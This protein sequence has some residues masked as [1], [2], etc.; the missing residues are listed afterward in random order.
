MGW[1]FP[2]AH[3][4]NPLLRRGVGGGERVGTLFWTLFPCQS[5]VNGALL[6]CPPWLLNK[7]PSLRLV[8]MLAPI[9]NDWALSWICLERCP[10]ILMAVLSYLTLLLCPP[11]LFFSHLNSFLS[12]SVYP[13]VTISTIPF[14]VSIYLSFFDC[15]EFSHTETRTG[16]NAD[17]GSFSYHIVI[18]EYPA[19][20]V[21]ACMNRGAAAFSHVPCLRHIKARCCI[22]WAAISL[23]WSLCQYGSGPG[24][25]PF[26]FSPARLSPLVNEALCL[27]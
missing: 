14:F 23:L 12:N 20:Q 24:L 16:I 4:A 21:T 15:F 17:R 19:L 13:W 18:D 22:P 11:R 9:L 6:R 10:S 26:R 2:A 8:S 7:E 27:N 1:L 5:S 3:P 25:S